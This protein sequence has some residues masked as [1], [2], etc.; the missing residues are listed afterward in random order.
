M[1]CTFSAAH[2]DNI[3]IRS[4]LEYQQNCES[5]RLRIDGQISGSVRNIEHVSSNYQVHLYS[6]SITGS[7]GSPL[8]TEPRNPAEG[9]QK[10]Q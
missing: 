1:F 2:T 7:T 6:N 3:G 8:G 9:S 10:E 5:L 4:S